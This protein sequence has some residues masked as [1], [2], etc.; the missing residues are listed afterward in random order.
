VWSLLGAKLRLH[1]TLGFACA[2]SARLVALITPLYLLAAPSSAVARDAADQSRNGDLNQPDYPDYNVG[3]SA[4]AAGRFVEALRIWRPLAESGDP[5]AA[6]GLG[7]LYD[8]GEGVGQDA[9][10]AFLWYRTAAEAGMAPAEFNIAVMFDS[11]VGTARNAAEAAVWYASAAAHG[12]ARAEYNLAQLYAAGDGVPRNLDVAK[13]WYAASAAH[14]L[15]AASSKLA[16]LRENRAAAAATALTKP[17]LIPVV[18]PGSHVTKSRAGEDN[19]V[20]LSWV[21][22]AQPVQVSFF[23]QVIALDAAGARPVFS[24]YLQQSAVLVRLPSR[25][26]AYAWR[27]YTV[28]ISE[29]DYIP[30]AWNYFSLR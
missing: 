30:S 22:P 27:V 2:S 19:V 6:Y 23:V 11:G 28:A 21:A 14:G 3:E 17:A 5:R 20:D 29:S 4:Y 15:S 18:A 13:A 26:A 1:N 7:L 10:A 16:S 9:A 12:I 8:L 24:S 25:P